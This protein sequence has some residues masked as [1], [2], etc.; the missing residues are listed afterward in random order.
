MFFSSNKEALGAV[1]VREDFILEVARGR[2]DQNADAHAASFLS[3]LARSQD[4]VPPAGQS[5]SHPAPGVEQ[6]E[7]RLA[8]LGRRG[9]QF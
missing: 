5:R 2:S 4:R 8:C 7:E 1:T 6:R 9:W 3:V